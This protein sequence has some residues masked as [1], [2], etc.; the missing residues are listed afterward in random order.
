MIVLLSTAD[1]DLLAARASGGTARGASQ[2]ALLAERA[3]APRTANPLASNRTTCAALLDGAWSCR[4]PAAGRAAHLGGRAGRGARSRA[5]PPSS[6]AA[7]PPRTP[8]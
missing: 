4:R 3:S 7:R 5:C 1:T 2:R 6:S 8:R